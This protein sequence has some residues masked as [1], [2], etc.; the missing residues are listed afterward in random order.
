[1]INGHIYIATN[2]GLAGLVKI[3][4]T[5]QAPAQR[6]AQFSTGAPHPFELAYSAPVTNPRRIEQAVHAH[7]APKRVNRGR[8]FFAVTVEEAKQVIRGISEEARRRD[9]IAAAEAHYRNM[10]KAAKTVLAAK[11]IWRW[12]VLT[13][14]KEIDALAALLALRDKLKIDDLEPRKDDPVWRKITYW[15]VILALVPLAGFIGVAIGAGMWK[16]LALIATAIT[17]LCVWSNAIDKRRR[18]RLAPACTGVVYKT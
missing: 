11:E 17:A 2:A 9:E 7:L 3:G 4:F 15:F 13:N 1:M 8:E 10:L 18:A 12:G 5:T 6:I 14:R 16:A